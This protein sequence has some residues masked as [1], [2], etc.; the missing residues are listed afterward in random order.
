MTSFVE[1][2]KTREGFVRVDLKKSDIAWM[3]VD[4]PTTGTDEI[5]VSKT[6]VRLAKHADR[7]A[8][9]RGLI[10]DL[11]TIEHSSGIPAAD[12]IAQIADAAEETPEAASLP[13]SRADILT[14][15]GSLE[16][17]PPVSRRAS[18][19]T[20]LAAARIV[21]DSLT[22]KD[23]ARLLGVG[24]S[25][26]RQRAAEGSLFAI[27]A[28]RPLRFPAFQ[29]TDG[30]ELPG[31]ADIAPLFPNDEHPAVVERFMVS[32]AVDLEI[33]GDSVSPRDWLLSGGDPAEVAALVNHVYRRRAE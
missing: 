4:Q 2:P 13:Q 24:E 10:A 9:V 17:M 28:R 26:V 23:V 1:Q 12:V 16:A 31:W 20:A 33:D 18:T 21:A 14:S 27:R 7:T 6:L 19:R 15:I 22:V 25:R 8:V 11:F 30:A 29:F 3:F 5:L 32:P